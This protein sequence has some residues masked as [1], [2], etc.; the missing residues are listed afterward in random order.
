MNLDAG[1]EWRFVQFT[2]GK[3]RAAFNSTSALLRRL[4]ELPKPE[5]EELQEW[6]PSAQSLVAAALGDSAD[7]SS[8]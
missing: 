5:H 6:I 7:G 1:V 3:A 2:V 4:L 8:A